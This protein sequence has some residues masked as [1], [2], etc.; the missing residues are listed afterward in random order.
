MKIAN[1]P[2]FHNTWEN[3]QKSLTNILSICHIENPDCYNIQTLHNEI[4]EIKKQLDT[5]K[6]IEKETWA[7]TIMEINKKRKKLNIL[8]I[9]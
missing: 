8:D 1:N 4:F 2:K 7:E 6:D 5:I 3:L 9:N